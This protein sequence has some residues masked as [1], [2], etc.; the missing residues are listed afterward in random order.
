MPPKRYAKFF[1]KIVM[2]ERLR[3]V[4]ALVGFTRIESPSD[5]DNPT[6][7]PENLG[8][9]FVRAPAPLG[10]AALAADPGLEGSYLDC[11]LRRSAEHACALDDQQA[12]G[13]RERPHV[14]R[15]ALEP[16]LVDHVDLP[17][18]ALRC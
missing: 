18:A 11:S 8:L 4:R 15:L 13:D 10:E 9:P 16:H 1:E 17:R 12:S 14:A 5:Y 6:A 7:F 2:A 3:E